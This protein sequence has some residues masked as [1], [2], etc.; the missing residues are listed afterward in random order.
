MIKISEWISALIYQDFVSLSAT[1]VHS[2]AANAGR[3]IKEAD[4]VVPG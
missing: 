3:S 2:C 1:E 4:S